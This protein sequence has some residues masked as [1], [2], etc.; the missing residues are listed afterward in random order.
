MQ[1]YKGRQF[2]LGS[3][4]C[5][6]LIR[7]Y[8]KEKYNVKLPDYARPE[9]YWNY[10]FNLFKELFAK[11]GFFMLEEN[12]E[13]WQEGDVFLIALG[14]EHATHAAIFLGE[15]KILHHPPYR[16]STIESYKGIWRNKTVMRVR[17]ISQKKRVRHVTEFNI[18]DHPYMR[19]FR[20]KLGDLPQKVIGS[21]ELSKR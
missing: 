16:L 12:P 21:A 3:S 5:Y 14:S 11:N 7:E 8:Y 19:R 13:T 17:H 20:E 6:S 4:D 18:L 10:G 9:D 1:N 2:K 15:N